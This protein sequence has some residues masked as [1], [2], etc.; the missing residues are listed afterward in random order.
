MF[1]TIFLTFAVCA[2]LAVAETKD[3]GQAI[4]LSKSAGF[5]HSCIKWD[6]SKISHVDKV[7]QGLT[8]ELGVSILCTKDASLIN[9]ENLKK[10][11]L[12]IFFTT[13]DLTTEGTD[14]QPPMGPNG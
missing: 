10:Y 9:A 11:K 5:E 13:A 14:K 6:D 12:V 8:K 2:C 1:R 4:F 7:L 3:A